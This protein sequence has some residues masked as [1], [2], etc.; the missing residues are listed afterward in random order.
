MSE[1][2][3]SSAVAYSTVFAVVSFTALRLSMVLVTVAGFAVSADAHP[4]LSSSTSAPRSSSTAFVA[5]S[6]ALPSVSHLLLAPPLAA[7]TDFL[8]LSSFLSHGPPL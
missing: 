3:S 2:S 8:G 4:A 5:D 7:A 6:T 1:A